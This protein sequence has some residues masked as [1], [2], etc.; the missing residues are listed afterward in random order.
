MPAT[1]SFLNLFKS[2]LDIE[3]VPCLVAFPLFCHVDHLGFRKVEEDVNF[4][5]VAKYLAYF[6][7]KTPTSKDSEALPRISFLSTLSDLQATRPTKHAPGSLE[8]R[9]ETI[10]AFGRGGRISL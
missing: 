3:T 4:Q 9:G 5:F 7:L 1:F 10:Q 8:D 2:K 6:G